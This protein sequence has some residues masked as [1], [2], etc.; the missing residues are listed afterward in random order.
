MA[1]DDTDEPVSAG[2]Y[3]EE[4]D[5]LA[6]LKGWYRED[7]DHSAQ[8][9]KDAEED[10]AFVSGDQWDETDKGA[11]RDQLRPVITFNR[12]GPV[13]DSVSGS[14]ISNRQEVRFIPREEGDARVNEVLTGAADWFRDQCDAEDEESDAFVDTVTCGMGWTD[15]RL[16]QVEDPDG[17][18]IIERVDPLEMFWDR[19][20]IKRNLGDCRRV[21]RVRTLDRAEA[22]EMFSDADPDE[23]HAGWTEDTE[24]E[25]EPH[26]ATQ[27]EFYP[28]QAT[29]ERRK[30]IRIAECQWW[31]I[32]TYYRVHDPESGKILDID[33]KQHRKL[34]KLAA[35]SGVDLRSVKAGRRKYMR[36]FIGSS[37][38]ESEPSPCQ[39][40]FTYR[41][42]TGKRDRNQG[43]WYGLVRAM[44]D[45]QRWANKWLSQTLHIMNS[46]AKGGILAETT[47]VDNVRKFEETWADPAAVTW[48]RDGA[49]AGQKIMPKPP[50][51]YPT[52]MPQLMEFA[53]SSIRDVTGV[54]LELLGLVDRNQAGVLEQQRKQAG[55]TILAGLFDSLRRYRKEQ[56]R[57]LLNYIKEYLSDD[58]LVRIVGE[59]GAEYVRLTRD[60]ATYTYD[61]IVDDAPASPNQKEATWAILQQLL[62]VIADRMPPEIWPEIIKNSPLPASFAE[63]VNA[64]LQKRAEQPPAPD[65]KL[66]E[67]Q[68][69]TEADIQVKQMDAQL[70]QQSSMMD[71]QIKQRETEQELALERERFELERQKMIFELQLKQQSHVMDLDKESQSMAMKQQA[72]GGLSNEGKLPDATGKI[73]ETLLS[74]IMDAQAKRDE[75][76][77][78]KI[79]QLFEAIKAPRKAVVERDPAGRIAGAVLQ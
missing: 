34:K 44:K 4:Q 17:K 36:A 40:S 53:V 57:I 74:G 68:K 56:G 78:K 58:R 71:A 79:V 55:M 30:K 25:G 14:E 19:S 76:Q 67:L 26:D 47:S 63:K 31:E 64:M 50:M 37:V 61:V 73:I 49:I 41:C 21:F 16:D 6:R 32:E 60:H 66:V 48:V 77:D 72:E 70:K 15:T 9:R 8:W 3:A 13:I 59:Q 11:L 12:V 62:P 43:T 5:L 20:A 65:P 35:D 29:G 75:V 42:I 24:D 69:K 1:T 18:V 45:P 33:A 54:N 2:D 38:L 22:Q 7:R 27:A 23:L 28:G 46:N 39:V 51:N 10:F 52:G